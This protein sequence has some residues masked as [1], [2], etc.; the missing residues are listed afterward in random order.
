MKGTD[1]KPPLKSEGLVHS[2]ESTHNPMLPEIAKNG[3]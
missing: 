2:E 3:Q 1:K